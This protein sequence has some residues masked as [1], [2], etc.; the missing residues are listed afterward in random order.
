MSLVRVEINGKVHTGYIY[1]DGANFW[2]HYEG[3]TFFIEDDSARASKKIKKG[4]HPLQVVAP[5]PGKIIKVATHPGKTVKTGEVVIVM[6]AM[7]MEYSLKTEMT[8]VVRGVN[9]KEGE[10]VTLGSVL[11]QLSASK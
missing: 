5:M 7:K 1:R 6:E 11:V 8:G 4:S 2:M 9:C 10:Q 3:K